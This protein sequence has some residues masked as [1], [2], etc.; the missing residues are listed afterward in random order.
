MMEPPCANAKPCMLTSCTAWA[1]MLQLPRRSQCTIRA[2]VLN[3]L[4]KSASKRICFPPAPAPVAPGIPFLLAPAPLPTPPPAPAAAL[5]PLPVLAVPTAG[6]P[7]TAA[8]AFPP[9]SPCLAPRPSRCNR[10]ISRSCRIRRCSSRSTPCSS[11]SSSLPAT[12][13]TASWGC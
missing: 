4:R 9:P 7:L 13:A 5:P 3:Y 1:Q 11:R 12:A 8:P 6:P 10:W 2:V